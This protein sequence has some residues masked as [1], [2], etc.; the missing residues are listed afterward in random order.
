MLANSNGL[1]ESS[2]EVGPSVLSGL[3]LA[4]LTPEFVAQTLIAADPATLGYVSPPSATIMSP[5]PI[6]VLKGSPNLQVAQRFVAFVL[7]AEGQALWALS[8]EAG[9]PQGGSLHRHPIRPDVYEQYAGKLVVKDNPFRLQQTMQFDAAL[10]GRYTTLLPVLIAAATEGE[11]HWLLQKA[12]RTA[13]Y[14][15]GGSPA[16]SAL[17]KPLFDQKAAIQYADDIAKNAARGTELRRQW[18]QEFLKRLGPS[19]QPAR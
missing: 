11:S 18:A 14:G 6:T 12:W 9:G 10:E 16:L 3:T 5:D 8:P 1:L 13:A 4:G 19:T 2:S 17:R 7:S 15:G